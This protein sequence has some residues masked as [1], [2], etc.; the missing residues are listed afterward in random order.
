[1]KLTSFSLRPSRRRHT[2]IEAFVFMILLVSVFVG[3]GARMGSNNLMLNT[4]FYLM[5]IT[6]LTGALSKLL[7]EFGVVSLVE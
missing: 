1:M 2:T 6:V 7:S 4:V 5:G 3:L